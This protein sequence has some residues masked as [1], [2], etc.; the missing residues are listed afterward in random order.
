M[1]R[2]NILL[3]IFFMSCQ[4]VQI[5]D[6]NDKTSED[7]Y[8]VMRCDKNFQIKIDGEIEVAWEK[9]LLLNDFQDHWNQKKV[10]QTAF[11]ALWDTNWLYFV[12]DVEDSEI[13]LEQGYSDSESNAVRSDRIELFRC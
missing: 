2:Y 11:R 1:V 5:Q 7:I 12:Y 10:G 8:K 6:G 4:F 13:I 9:A 3:L